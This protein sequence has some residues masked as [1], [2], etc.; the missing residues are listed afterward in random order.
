MLPISAARPTARATPSPTKPRRPPCSTRVTAQDALRA[1]P[2]PCPK[3][4]GVAARTV[5]SFRCMVM[6]VS[7]VPHRESG[8]LIEA[9]D[10]VAA[11]QDVGTFRGAA[12]I[13][14]IR[15]S[16]CQNPE[17][18]SIQAPPEHLTAVSARLLSLPPAKAEVL[19]CCF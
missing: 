12:E 11:Y 8:R 19:A 16:P 18:R 13:W 4:T 2:Y 10:V 7:S 5:I 3:L 15:P 6:R 14:P 17:N 1:V 9:D